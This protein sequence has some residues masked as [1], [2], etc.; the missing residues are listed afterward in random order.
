MQGSNQ[1]NRPESNTRSTSGNGVS[2][3]E[4]QT[5]GGFHEGIRVSGASETPDDG[6]RRNEKA[7]KVSLTVGSLEWPRDGCPPSAPPALQAPAESRPSWGHSIDLYTS[8]G[9]GFPP[10]PCNINSSAWYRHKAERF[11]DLCAD[12]I[13]GEEE[14]LAY[15]AALAAA[16]FGGIALKLYALRAGELLEAH[17]DWRVE[18]HPGNFLLGVVLLLMSAGMVAGLGCC[19]FAAVVR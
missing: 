14:G 12:M 18:G 6:T 16:H 5:F 7:I 13:A 2:P 19:A 1:G 11:G 17:P 10:D 3:R 9:L 15:G 8:E 4:S